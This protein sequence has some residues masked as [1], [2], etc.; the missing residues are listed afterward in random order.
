MVHWLC[1][2]D[3]YLKHAP[4]KTQLGDEE[5]LKAYKLFT[6]C[7][8][9]MMTSRGEQTYH[10]EIASSADV[11]DAVQRLAPNFACG[12]LD[13][14]A[15]ETV[16]IFCDAM[17]NTNIRNVKGYMKSIIWNGF[18]EFPMNQETY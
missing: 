3:F 7:L 15:I 5:H 1:E 18:S 17:D 12:E 11:R 13:E 2:Y 9:S 6:E 8:C 14:F 16:K 4:E 10:D